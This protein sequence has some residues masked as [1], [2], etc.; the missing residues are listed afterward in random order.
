MWSFWAR[1]NRLDGEQ[2]ERRFEALLSNSS[3]LVLVVGSAGAIRYATPM[4]QFRP[5]GRSPGTC[6]RPPRARA[7]TPRA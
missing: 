1:R 3:D 5:A 2:R 6:A 7:C 4:R